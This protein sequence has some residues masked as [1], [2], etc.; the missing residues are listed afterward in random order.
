MSA[1]PS[2]EQRVLAGRYRL[3]EQLGSGGFGTIWRAE[4]LVL[5]APVAVK[6]IAAEVAEDASAV[7]RF[8]REAKA[9]A[10][11][12][13]P[14]VVQILDYGVDA[15]TPFMVMELLEGENLAQRLRRCGPLSPEDTVK[16]ITHV[17]RAMARAHAA[18][19]VHRDL[20]PENV[21]IVDNE[22]D[23]LAKVLDFGVAKLDNGLSSGSSRTRTGSLLGTPY[24]MSPEQ[25]QGTKEVDYRSDLWSIGV[26]AYE[27][28]SGEK[29]F[30]SDGL[31]ELVLQI[32]VR[33]LPI[34][35]QSCAAMSEEFDAWFARA[36]QRDPDQR[37]QSASEL[38]N[39]LRDCLGVEVRET[40]LSTSDEELPSIVGLASAPTVRPSSG[41]ADAPIEREDVNTPAVSI[42]RIVREELARSEAREGTSATVWVALVALILGLAGGFV[43]LYKPDLPV[44]R[45]LLQVL[46]QDKPARPL[47]PPLP[48]PSAA[49]AAAPEPKVTV[50]DAGKPE[51]DA[52]AVRPRRGWRSSPASADSKRAWLGGRGTDGQPDASADGL[53]VDASAPSP[54]A[55]GLG[56]DADEV[57]APTDVDAGGPLQFGSSRP[58]RSTVPEDSAPL[59]PHRWDAPGE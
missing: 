48:K 40:M 14:H 16:F 4:H 42:G 57:E 7:E 50:E 43:Y 53:A 1:E 3:V 31:G 39:A 27:C 36:L 19:V 56:E 45:L 41:S 11:L 52:G 17:C 29:P 33:P 37:F 21:F 18:G 26:I 5:E 20:K 10:A 32:C 34:P 38:G 35:S 28:L 13:S 59:P 47:P 51:Q 6:L 22:G 12:R 15:G 58:A 44:L 2:Q 55:S 23:E 46:P 24:Y 30:V 49:R 8:L 9:A 54:H 25:V